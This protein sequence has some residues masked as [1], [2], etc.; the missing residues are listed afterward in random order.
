[1]RVQDLLAVYGV[2]D[3]LLQV[4]A[5]YLRLDEG[6]VPKSNLNQ[7]SALQLVQK[8]GLQPVVAQAI[9]RWRHQN[10]AFPNFYA[11]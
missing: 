11:L 9:V 4:L 8:A 10:G 7:A 5:P 3:S 1:M 6:R 2:K